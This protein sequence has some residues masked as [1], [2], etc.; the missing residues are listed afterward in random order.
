IAVYNPKDWSKKSEMSTLIRDNR[1]NHVCAADYSE[2][3]E[4]DTVVKAIIDKC[5]ADHKLALL[6][7]EN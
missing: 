1:V 3:S 4:I 5:V 2:G 7:A 6:E